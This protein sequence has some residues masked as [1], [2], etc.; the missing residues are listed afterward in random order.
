MA[1]QIKASF[2]LSGASNSRH[3]HLNNR[4]DNKYAV[5][6]ENGYPDNTVKLVQLMNN[7]GD[8]AP[9]RNYAPRKMRMAST[10]SRMEKR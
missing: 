2:M 1:E 7:R 9:G 10:L 6:Q 3:Q 4:L 8:N 5:K